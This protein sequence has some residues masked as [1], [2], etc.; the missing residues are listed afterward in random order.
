MPY[1]CSR[2]ATTRHVV[3]GSPF[4]SGAL[5]PQ[6][7]T[8]SGLPGSD[9]AHEI[10]IKG[11]E[12]ATSTRFKDRDGKER[13]EVRVTWWSDSEAPV[14]RDR[15]TVFGHYWNVPPSSTSKH[16]T[17]PHP[18]GHPEL[19]NWQR[20]HAAN[21]PQRGEMGLAPNVNAICVDYNGVFNAG[22]GSCVG[23]Y[24]WPEHQV[25]WARCAP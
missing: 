21:V 9:C 14:P 13:G 10:L 16:A 24:R 1:L 8:G 20:A 2:P 6:L 5:H 15:R 4:Q 3:L 18:S 7:P 12:N 11:Y 17:P 19:R 23:G 22:A 25:A